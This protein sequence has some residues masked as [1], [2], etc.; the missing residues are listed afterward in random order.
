MSDA[1]SA[2][3]SYISVGDAASPNTY[4]EIAEVKNIGGPNESSDEIQVT[5]LRSPSNYHEFLQSFKDGGEI[6]CV[7][8]YIPSNATHASGASG[9]RGLF[10]SGENRGWKIT[11]ADGTL[12]YFDGYVKALGTP[13]QVGNAVELNFTIRVTGP[14]TADEAA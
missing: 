3:Q 14:V 7:A 5:H 11:L 2:Q 12:L 1:F 10:A 13:I 9:L 4:T 6:P 8:N